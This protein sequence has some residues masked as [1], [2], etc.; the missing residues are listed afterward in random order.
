VTTG[1]FAKFA[2]YYAEHGWPVIP[3]APR[4]KIPLTH[5]GL[6]DASCDVDTVRAWWRRW[7]QANIG[8]RTGVVFDVVD[9]DSA[10]GFDQLRLAAG[11]WAGW[12]GPVVHTGHGRHFYAATV[13]GRRSKI[14]FLDGCDYKAADAYVIAPPSI[15]P[16]GRRYRFSG[17]SSGPDAPLYSPPPWLAGLLDPPARPAP[18]APAFRPSA[19]NRF[20]G[21]RYALAALRSEA[22]S[23]AGAAEG[24]RN[25]TL[26]LAAFRMRRLVEAGHLTEGDVLGALLP[27]A[28]AA[29]FIRA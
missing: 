8:I 10:A 29:G 26:N 14:R 16:S 18:S 6:H 5:H 2:Q 25:D 11:G 3:C 19:G 24:I 15:H 28:A 23:V 27:A 20:E 4:S 9:V 1:S 22:A 13:S 21:L 7:P 17:P 12:R